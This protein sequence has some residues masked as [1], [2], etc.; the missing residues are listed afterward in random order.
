VTS[1][2]YVEIVCDRCDE[3]ADVGDDGPFASAREL[4]A[5]L[6]GRGWAY[7][8]KQARIDICPSCLRPRERAARE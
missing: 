4:R 8:T 1:F 6:S 3:I 5:Y 2:R 7:H